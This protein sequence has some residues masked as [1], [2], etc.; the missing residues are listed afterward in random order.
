MQ[1]SFWV[2][3]VGGVSQRGRMEQDSPSLLE[4]PVLTPNPP[5]LLSLWEYLVFRWREKQLPN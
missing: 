5:L 2:L 4:L 3:F 1:P